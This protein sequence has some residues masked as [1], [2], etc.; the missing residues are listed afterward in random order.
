MILF[1]QEFVMS[2][3]N[4]WLSEC[5]YVYYCTP[6]THGSI[7][8]YEILNTVYINAINLCFVQSSPTHG[9]IYRYG[10]FNT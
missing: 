4:K 1:I 3:L 7:Y 9:S 5:Q 2:S 6:P 10:D 8:R